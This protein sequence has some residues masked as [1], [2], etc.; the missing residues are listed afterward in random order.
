MSKLIHQLGIVVLLVICVGASSKKEG[1]RQYVTES[2][3]WFRGEEGSRITANVLS[4]QSPLGSWPKN[5]DT[6]ATLY[7]GDPSEL[8]GTF[9]N[10]ATTDELRFLAGAFSATKQDRCKD[11][12]VKGLDHIFKAQYP[13]GGWPTDNKAEVPK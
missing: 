13:T 10:G 2:D 8:H 11:A 7:T 3:D 1:V 9:D 6:T 4:H 5:I 12:F